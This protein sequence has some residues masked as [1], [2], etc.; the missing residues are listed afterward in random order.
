MASKLVEA[1]GRASVVKSKK[2]A[3]SFEF[4][5]NTHDLKSEASKFEEFSHR[6]CTYLNVMDA[7]E[8]EIQK[9]ELQAGK[10]D[11][12]FRKLKLAEKVT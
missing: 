9:R 12:F 3:K 5:A 7:G 10:W 4:Y 6:Y 2:W 1:G 11:R 8:I